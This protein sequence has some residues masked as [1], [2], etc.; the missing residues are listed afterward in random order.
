MNPTLVKV[1][2]FP[3][4]EINGEH[5]NY[6]I[7]WQTEGNVIGIRQKGEQKVVDY[8]I[9]SSGQLH[10]FLQKLSPNESYFIW[11]R[12]YTQNNY[13]SNDSDRIVVNVFPEPHN[14]ELKN[15]TAYT[16]EVQ[17]TILP[18][19]KEFTIQFSKITL[20]FWENI[21]SIDFTEEKI[22]IAKISNLQ[23]KMQYKFRLLLKYTNNKYIYTWPKD[24]RF[25]YETLG[26]MLRLVILRKY[27][28][29]T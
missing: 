6:E 29:V 8:E 11:V 19:I 12:A 1:S 18:V 13:T 24:M 22:I 14:I 27:T 10:T 20:N 15:A 16:L 4:K 23:P 9:D 21:T 28:L 2:W 26:K 7:H 5:V 17:W 3:P 25:T